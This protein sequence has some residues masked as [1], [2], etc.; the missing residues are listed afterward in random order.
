M[1]IDKNKAYQ[2]T[3]VQWLDKS[4]IT[5]ATSGKGYFR[6]RNFYCDLGYE[7]KEIK[8]IE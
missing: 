6:L 7:I 1:R 5:L 8:I 4:T 2:V 3:F